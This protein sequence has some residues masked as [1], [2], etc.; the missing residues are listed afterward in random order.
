MAEWNLPTFD[1]DKDRTTA[2][3]MIDNVGGADGIRTKII[4]GA[5]GSTTMLRTRN[6]FPHLKTDRLEQK[7]QDYSLWHG[8][9][10]DMKVA[11]IEKSIFYTMGSLGARAVR[12]NTVQQTGVKNY[13]PDQ[14]EQVYSLSV[15]ADYLWDLQK[16][17]VTKLNVSSSA[18]LYGN[19]FIKDASELSLSIP[20]LQGETYHVVTPLK[21]ADLNGAAITSEL[22]V[23][24]I[25]SEALTMNATPP[26]VQSNGVVNLSA[27]KTMVI[28]Q[29]FN[30]VQYN[31]AG[32]KLTPNSGG[33]TSESFSASAV[34]PLVLDTSSVSD[35]GVGP[36]DDTEPSVW[37]KNITND[38]SGFVGIYS[39][40]EGGTTVH[41]V[42]GG[43]IEAMFE[44]A[45]ST[46]SG[47]HF[48]ETAQ[49]GCVREVTVDTQ[50]LIFKVDS[51]YDFVYRAQRAMATEQVAGYGTWAMGFGYPLAY[52]SLRTASF[53]QDGHASIKAKIG[54]I[55]IDILTASGFAKASG[56]DNR[57][58][59]IGHVADLPLTSPEGG[60][61]Y[62]VANGKQLPSEPT[63]AA[64]QA[65]F[66]DS[67]AVRY[68]AIDYYGKIDVRTELA[69]FNGST[70][71]NATGFYV[72]DC[73]VKTSFVAGIECV[74]KADASFAAASSSGVW[75]YGENYK[76]PHEVTVYFTWIWRGSKSRKLLVTDIVT[77]RPCFPMR[78]RQNPF[79]PDS[80]DIPLVHMTF[81]EFK[82][83]EETFDQLRN[84]RNHQ[85]VDSCYAGHSVAE[86]AVANETGL[87]SSTGSTRTTTSG[88]GMVYHRVLAKGDLASAVW[89]LDTMKISEPISLAPLETDPVKTRAYGFSDI[90]YKAIFDTEYR[91]SLLD[92]VESDWSSTL[93]AD[94]SA[95]FECKRV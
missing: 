72:I 20:V 59:R 86:Q 83:G 94:P 7:Q 73:D 45:P 79:L 40:G 39:F 28:S 76:I 49:H 64:M 38:T 34:A 55:E 29:T 68:P 95:T 44:P 85:G 63:L 89:L 48:K 47:W 16:T 87:S 18:V 31:W 30:I 24:D 43:G 78:Q 42:V 33:Y 9:V 4:T 11:G 67:M 75:D 58:E 80:S 8:I 66:P 6:G 3:K 82:M 21:V 56:A 46:K 41:T 27:Y 17:P 37:W 22:S 77:K 52:V 2:R 53:T 93:T 51:N 81:P 1:G 92:G 69:L 84:L 23:P 70:S 65:T 91:I 15:N 26:V 50:P 61:Y 10:V 32:V 71:C 60:I 54:D 57:W 12:Q 62:F 88:V 35:S 90:L 14:V 5:D 25:G 13:F 19:T 36:F 74:V